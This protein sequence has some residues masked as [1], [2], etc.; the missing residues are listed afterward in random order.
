MIQ[1]MARSGPLI[2]RYHDTVEGYQAMITQLYFTGDK[3][4][5]KHSAASL[6]A[7]KSRILNIKDIAGGEKSVSF[8]VT[9]LEKVPADISVIDR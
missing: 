7:A 3:N 8:N 5:A 9:M 1:V 2:T 6:P 4:I